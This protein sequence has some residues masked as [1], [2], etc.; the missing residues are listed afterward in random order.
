[1]KTDIVVTGFIFNEGKLLLIHHKKLDL[2]LPVGGHIEQN[3]IPH[4]ALAREIAE[5]TGLA[6]E[7]V[8]PRNLPLVGSL[9]QNCPVPFNV[10]LH[11]VGDHD[12]CSLDFVCKAVNP[13]VL[14][15]NKEVI[16]A[17]WLTEEQV[18][19]DVAIRADIRNIALAA[20]KAQQ[21]HKS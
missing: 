4:E 12:H 6:V 8:P 11:N 13:E 10:N 2:W 18:R 17:R 7:F 16:N 5:E 20:F 9:R 14:A 19:H 3:E 1:M 21:F 15:L